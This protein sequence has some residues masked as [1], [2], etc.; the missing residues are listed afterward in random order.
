MDKS[1]SDFSH[2]EQTGLRR[3][4]EASEGVAK[5]V[6][7]NLMSFVTSSGECKIGLRHGMECLS[8][9]GTLSHKGSCDYQMTI[10]KVF[11]LDIYFN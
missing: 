2:G 6:Y 3:T 4:S 8:Y 10:K 11:L 5:E 7:S 1:V 9:G